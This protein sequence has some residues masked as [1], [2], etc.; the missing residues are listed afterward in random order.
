MLL[1]QLLIVDENVEGLQH[2]L[3]VAEGVRLTVIVEDDLLLDGQ[4]LFVLS[5]HSLEKG[6]VAQA[7]FFALLV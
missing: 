3:A 6:Q 7:D 5:Q 4:N 1:K 2:L